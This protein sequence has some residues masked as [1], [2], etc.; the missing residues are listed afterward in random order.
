MRDTEAAH[1]STARMRVRVRSVAW[2]LV[3]GALVGSCVAIAVAP[4]RGAR[5]EARQA[6]FVAAPRPQDWPREPGPGERVRLEYGLDGAT[7]VVTSR[8]AAGA[9]ALARA[10]AAWQAPTASTLKAA[11]AQLRLEW[12]AEL[13]A[14]NPPH[15]TPR[16]ECASLLLARS[17]WGRTLAD[18]LP[19][20]AP[21]APPGTVEAPE[22]VLA[23]WH[24]VRSA[25]AAEQPSR[26]V[27]AIQQAATEETDW[28]AQAAT[29]RGVTVAA[30]A[31]LWRRWQDARASELEPMA[32]Q[33]LTGQTLLQR[34]F[35]ELA[36]HPHMVAFDEELPDPWQPF[37]S[38]DPA[39]L[40]PLVRPIARVWLPP[41]L[42]G[43]FAGAM[44]LLALT[45]WRAWSRS[46][47]LA[48]EI[49][50]FGERATDASDAGPGLHVVTGPT[51]AVVTRGALELAARRLALGERVLLVDG[52]ARL[53]L[54]ERL[55]RDA[56]WGLL[57]C[58]AAEMPVLG[59]VQYAG[60]P[61]LY[62]LA[63]GN[64]DRAVGWSRLGQKLDEVVPHFGRI[65]LALDPHAPEELGDALRG[66]AME[67][68]WGAL[69]A[70]LGRAAESTTAR[71][72][73]VFHTL[74]LEHMPEPTLEAMAARV[75][76]LR[77]E[78][79]VP[80]PAPITAPAVEPLSRLQLPALEPIVLDCDLLM[81]E[82]LR[83]L[84]WM[85]RLQATHREADLQA[86]S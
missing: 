23:A 75:T 4:P 33:L 21:A 65:V 49:E 3:V 72:G 28:F 62:L 6:W 45:L 12:R 36:A 44:V 82:R 74:E 11:L 59:L 2:A 19:L 76:S 43:A 86:S 52:S 38:P 79:P 68:W 17:I 42:W 55:G 69:D 29:W 8:D 81:I 56:R 39:S 58:L 35:A 7:L 57:E 67:G 25:A 30:R 41:L 47:A 54:H 27:T 63:H 5:F 85:R 14:E 34:R 80:E 66:R 48:E 18:H 20:P 70:G 64:A 22:R 15:R 13:P 78:G 10:F 32:E 53:H 9:R 24:E 16:A 37:A 73:I 50:R 51:P 84:A 26:L 61:G 60:H 46:R 77:P 31:E 1:E 71:L 83:F 40:R